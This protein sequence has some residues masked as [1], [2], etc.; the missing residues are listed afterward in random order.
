MAAELA[1]AASCSSDTTAPDPVPA[2]LPPRLPATLESR[3][4]PKA[5]AGTSGA[6]SVRLRKDGASVLLEGLPLARRDEPSWS[7]CA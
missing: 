7:R 2:A 1:D 4:M 6:S 5:A 3:M